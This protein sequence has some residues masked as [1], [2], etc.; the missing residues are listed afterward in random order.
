MIPE[1]IVYLVYAT[2]KCFF[3]LHLVS[4]EDRPNLSF[5]CIDPL[6]E[7]PEKKTTT[8]YK[9]PARTPLIEVI[10]DGEEEEEFKR[11]RVSSTSIDSAAA[12]SRP[13]TSAQSFYDPF[14]HDDDDP[15]L[16]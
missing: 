4:S 7:I 3:S 2:N 6:R 14:V 1:G 16:L 9:R 13:L 12:A 15:V 8:A 11:P 10:D 5:D